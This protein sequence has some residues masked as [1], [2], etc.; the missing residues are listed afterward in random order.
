[1]TQKSD[2]TIS[3][4]YLDYVLRGE[5]ADYGPAKGTMVFRPYGYALW[6][7][8][9]EIFNPMMK[10]AGVQNAYFPLF[11][12]YS[13]LEKEKEHVAGFSPELAVVTHGGG[14]KLAEPLVVRPTSETIMYQLYAKW[15]QSWRD[16]PILINQWNNVV[17]WEKR[18]FPFIRT[19]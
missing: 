16:L 15:L 8:V 5:L 17:R 18:T 11:I 1:M 3:E 6:E 19:S 7:R 10:S 14:E 13:L 12:P 4:R 2:A 9:Q